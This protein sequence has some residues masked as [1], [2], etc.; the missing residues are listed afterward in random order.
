MLSLQCIY[1]VGLNQIDG[2]FAEAVG[3]LAAILQAT[4]AQQAAGG[5]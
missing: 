4:A 1:E 3:E 2:N 5:W